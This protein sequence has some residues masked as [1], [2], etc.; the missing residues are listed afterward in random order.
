MER[1]AAAA[2]RRFLADGYQKTTM[3]SLAADAGVVVQTIY[4]TVG[5]KAAVLSLVLDRT[6]SGPEFPRPVPGFMKERTENLPDALSV[7]ETLA[8][9]FA[10]VH[11]RS[12]QV[13]ELIRQA[14]AVDPEVA[15]LENRREAQRLSNYELAAAV[16]ADKGELR[17]PIRETA[18]TIWAVGHPSVYRRLVMAGGWSVSDYRNWVTTTLSAALLPDS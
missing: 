14:A 12:A 1:I 8:D 4:N 2:T 15:E 5:G 13:F 7:I 16:I 17:L 9:W 10:E 3:L 6:V 11:P 18:A